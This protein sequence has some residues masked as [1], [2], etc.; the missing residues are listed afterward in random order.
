MKQLTTGVRGLMKLNKVSTFSGMGK[1][2]GQGKVS[3]QPNEGAA[4]EIAREA[5]H[6]RHRERAGGIAE[7]EI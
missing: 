7:H 1:I 4:Q 3:I 6:H 5:H 2:S